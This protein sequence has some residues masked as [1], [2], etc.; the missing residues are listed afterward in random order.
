[1]TERLSPPSTQETTQPP[2]PDGGRIANSEKRFSP[3][4][5]LAWCAILALLALV[6]FMLVRKMEGPASEGK[7]APRFTLTTFN[8]GT[9]APADMKEKVVVVNFWASWCKP[10]EQEAAELEAAWRYYQPRGDVIFL[11]VDYV[12]TEPE[13]KAYLEKFNITY[14]NGPD[15]GTRIS[16]AFR[17]IGVPETYIVDK[18]GNL[19]HSQIGV[20]NTVDEIKSVIDPLLSSTH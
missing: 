17:I 16:Q 18:S 11:G 20:F 5:I 8:G 14:P 12:D 2:F 6:A 4:M 10:C 9:V 1:M 19:V 13:A 15:L 3:G 7:R